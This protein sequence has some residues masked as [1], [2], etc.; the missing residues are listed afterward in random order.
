[1]EEEEK[2]YNYFTGQSEH[3]VQPTQQF[4]FT[5]YDN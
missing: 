2:S 5:H 4:C 1:M 3:K